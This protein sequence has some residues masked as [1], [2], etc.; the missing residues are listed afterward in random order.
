MLFH[1][2][3]PVNDLLTELLNA[4]FFRGHCLCI[5]VISFREERLGL[6]FKTTIIAELSTY[7]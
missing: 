7:F 3:D 2:L 6:Q 5:L 1:G 4:L